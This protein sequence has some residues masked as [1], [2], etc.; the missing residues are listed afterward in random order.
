MCR[1]AS[2]QGRHNVAL[3][4]R[5]LYAKDFS[6]TDNTI[7]F[8]FEEVR[9][10]EKQ[11]RVRAVFDGVAENYDLMNDLMSLGVHR[12]W[13][14]ILLDKADPKNA[15]GPGKV[16]IDVAGG[17]G[18]IALGFLGRGGS[19]AYVCD[20]NHA[21]LRVGTERKETALLEEK[22]LHWI[23]GNAECLPLPD[24]TADVYTI[25]FGI[26][27]VTHRDQALRQARRVL[28]PG[29]RFLCL[30]FSMPE[31]PGTKKF[32][33]LYSFQILPW[34]GKTVA[35]DADSY[36]Y[37]AES[38]RKFPAPQDF[39]AQIE[40][41]GLKNV[42]FQNLTGGIATLYSAWRL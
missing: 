38:I 13:K 23:C 33:D 27:N 42:T 15:S 24:K 26:R 37:L 14:S 2:S 41:A 18:D 32:Y 16:L 19:T 17:T 5:P 3:P 21:M 8:G 31:M 35:N 9:V 29:G 25:T 7:D 36:R 10:D 12:I 20:I 34:I 28:K 6:M 11:G 22:P 39:A 4:A 30:E 1:L 40:E